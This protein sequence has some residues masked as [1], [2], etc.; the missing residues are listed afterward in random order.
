MCWV[1]WNLS[2]SISLVESEL[3]LLLLLVELPG[4]RRRD[5]HPPDTGTFDFTP[6]DPDDLLPDIV[7]ARPFKAG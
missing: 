6:D 5:S 7:D 2:V 4:L 3:S 1:V